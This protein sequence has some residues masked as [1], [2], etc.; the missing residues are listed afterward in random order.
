MD[1]QLNIENSLPVPSG[2]K[3][4]KYVG[5]TPCENCGDDADYYEWPD[6]DG[7]LLRT[8]ISCIHCGASND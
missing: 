2:Q 1:G 6:V 5:A 3:P 4:I 8:Q 7:G